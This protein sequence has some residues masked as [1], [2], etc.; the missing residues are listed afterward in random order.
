M[1]YK[2]G[3]L[4]LYVTTFLMMSCSSENSVSPDVNN[5]IGNDQLEVT[6]LSSGLSRNLS[7]DVAKTDLDELV[8]GNNKF[9]LD[10]YALLAQG[11]ENVF[12]SPFSISQA[13]AMVYAGAKGETEAQ[14][15]S[16]L[17]FTLSQD[18]LHPAFNALDLELAGRSIPENE[19]YDLDCFKLHIA[20]SMWGSDASLFVTDFLD[21]LAVNYGAGLQILDFSKNPD[22]ARLAINDWVSKNTGRKINDILPYGSIDFQTQ[23]VLVNAIYFN[24]PWDLPFEKDST[25]TSSF[26]HI[27]GHITDAS[28]M[29]Q[30]GYF[31][32]VKTRCYQ[33][34]EMQYDGNKMS[35]VVIKPYREMLGEFEAT[36]S[37]E[38]FNCILG[39]MEEEYISIEMP[40][41]SYG[42][43][44]ISL[45]G[46]LSGM[47]MPDC[48]GGAADL[49]GISEVTNLELDDIVHKAFISVDEAGTE[50]A[51]ATVGMFPSSS[52]ENPIDFFI[53]SPFLIVIRDIITG[54]ILFTG[55]IVNPEL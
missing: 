19:F 1:V 8:N 47:G 40:K 38:Q 48:F 30:T 44:T 26:K 15:K 14:M 13:L 27:D 37:D 18:D 7:P 3:C 28:F 46:V 2:V 43:E 5:D 52:G 4:I 12:F 10:L 32:H 41:F 21:I 54:T 31:R 25:F 35:M 11:D 55:R 17:H 6:T 20:N 50:A 53:N 49:S 22:K 36:M 45:K 42:S 16:T 33:A 24:A 29:H 23:L 51:A 9:A 34:V 39:L